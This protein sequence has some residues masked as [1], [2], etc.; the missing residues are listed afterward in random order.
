[1]GSWIIGATSGWSGVRQYCQS[2]PVKCSFF[3]EKKKNIED[4]SSTHQWDKRLGGVMGSAEISTC[5]VLLEIL[6]VGNRKQGR[7]DNVLK[8][9]SGF[10]SSLSGSMS[11]NLVQ[12]KQ[13]QVTAN[14]N[15]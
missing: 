4:S 7:Q 5:A 3:E 2:Q 1:M 14:T 15:T 9:E 12:E 8:T 11:Q 6:G 13:N 10:S